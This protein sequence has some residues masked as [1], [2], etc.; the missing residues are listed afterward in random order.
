MQKEIIVFLNDQPCDIVH[1]QD[2]K[3]LLDNPGF[4]Q[5]ILRALFQCQRAIIKR[6][7]DTDNF[8]LFQTTVE[9]FLELA[10]DWYSLG[11]FFENFNSCTTDSKDDNLHKIKKNL[12]SIQYV[13]L[14]DIS[15]YIFHKDRDNKSKYLVFLKK[16]LP[17]YL[18]DFA[19]L[20]MKAEESTWSDITEWERLSQNYSLRKKASPLA[21]T[22]L[23]WRTS[24]F[25][26]YSMENRLSKSSEQNTLIEQYSLSFLRKISTELPGAI[27][28][29]RASKKISEEDISQVKVL[30][31]FVDEMK[32]YYDRH[33]A[34]N[35]EDV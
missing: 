30:T 13:I 6:I 25:W 5:S 31:D 18:D 16:Y 12:G 33:S 7:F 11:L 15:T 27:E 20:F 22:S 28:Q 9:S 35:E 32:S 4:Y 23:N 17:R 1:H 2:G 29:I 26:H 14:Y 34:T 19:Y 3:L 8:N 21:S 10:E 24:F